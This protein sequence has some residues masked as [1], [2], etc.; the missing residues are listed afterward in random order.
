MVSAR[1]SLQEAG[2]A[3]NLIFIL[4]STDVDV[5]ATRG[6]LFRSGKGF[7]FSYVTIPGIKRQMLK[8]CL[9]L[10]NLALFESYNR[11]VF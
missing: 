5:R 1:L 10:D 2:R 11:D 3:T 6:V 7:N 4:S 9:S 8:L